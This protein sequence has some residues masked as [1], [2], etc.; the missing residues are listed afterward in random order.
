MSSEY[1]SIIKTGAV[2]E[3]NSK[4]QQ[5]LILKFD[6]WRGYNKQFYFTAVHMSELL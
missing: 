6:K 2:C 1:N 3:Q 4:E 5:K